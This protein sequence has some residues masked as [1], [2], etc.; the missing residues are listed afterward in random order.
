MDESQIESLLVWLVV[1]EFGVMKLYNLYG[2]IGST[3]IERVSESKEFS[4]K[5]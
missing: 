2:I 1:D 3:L 4:K 5:D